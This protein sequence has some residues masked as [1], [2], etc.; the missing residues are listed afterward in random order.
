MNS[1]AYFGRVWRP[2]S[3]LDVKCGDAAHHGPRC[4]LNHGHGQPDRARHDVR[5]A[6]TSL[7]VVAA[8]GF[9]LAG[10]AAVPLLSVLVSVLSLIPLGRA[11]I[12]GGAAIWPFSHGETGGASLCCCGLLLDQRRRQCG[13]AD[14]HQPRL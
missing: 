7:A 3:M 10:V 4:R 5:L 6:R 8:I 11:F 13:A 14:A 2:L 12:W 1:Y 9:A